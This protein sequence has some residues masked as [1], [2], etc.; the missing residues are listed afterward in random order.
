MYMGEISSGTDH[1]NLGC[2][3]KLSIKIYKLYWY[4]HYYY[5]LLTLS[6]S[7]VQMSDLCLQSHR[8]DPHRENQKWVIKK[9]TK[10]K[11]EMIKKDSLKRSKN[12]QQSLFFQLWSQ[13][14]ILRFYKQKWPVADSHFCCCSKCNNNTSHDHSLSILPPLMIITMI[15]IMTVPFQLPRW[16]E[17]LLRKSWLPLLDLAS[18]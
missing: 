7:G 9:I 12:K 15:T 2:L 14:W 6:F 16:L 11:L 13:K 5:D 8:T 3:D 18:P 1:M 17:Q 10:K 4:Y